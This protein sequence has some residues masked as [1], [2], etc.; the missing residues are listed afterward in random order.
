[1]YSLRFFRPNTTELLRQRMVRALI[2]PLLDYCSVL[3]N[4]TTYEQR[5]RLQRLQNSC[6]RRDHVTPRGAGLTSC[7]LTQDGNTSLTYCYT[8]SLIFHLHLIYGKCLK[9]VSQVGLQE[10]PQGTLKFHGCTLR[11]ASNRFELQMCGCGIP[12]HGALKVYQV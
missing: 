7:A 3:T 12:C 8:K 5:C 10:G 1:M 9:S 6:L 4:D 2:F 11:T